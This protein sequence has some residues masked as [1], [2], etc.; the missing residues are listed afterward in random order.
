VL[1]K[2]FSA[3]IKKGFDAEPESFNWASWKRHLYQQLSPLQQDQFPLKSESSEINDRGADGKLVLR[4]DMN[5]MRIGYVDKMVFLAG[6]SRK[7][8]LWMYSAPNDARR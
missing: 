3:P 4:V 6:S 1:L 8:V 2:Q 5:P 7:G